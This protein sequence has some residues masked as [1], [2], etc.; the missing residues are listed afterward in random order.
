MGKLDT[1]DIESRHLK[2]VKSVFARYLSYKQ[3]WAYGSR[4]KWT[5]GHTSD[6]DCVIFNAT[7]SEIYN[8]QEAFD[9]SDIPF[10]VQLLNWKTIPDDFKKNIK[11]GYFVLRNKEDWSEFKLGDIVTLHYGKS[12]PTTK[13]MD[14]NI[15]VYS[16]A[17]LTGWHNKPL[18][19]S[20][21]LI[22]G[23][24]GT[25]GKVYKTKIPFFAID[26]AYYILPDENKYNFNYLYYILLELR[27]SPV[28]TGV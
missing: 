17:G 2:M 27:G 8:A 6:L 14:G 3:V 24:K 20:E 26:T 10:E 21:A 28:L 25:I 23:R 12:L 19:K 13:R 5:A 18:V 4:V 15:P 7:D 22:V 1:I 11:E 9:E 16:S